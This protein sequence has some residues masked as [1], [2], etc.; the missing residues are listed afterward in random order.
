MFKHQQLARKTSTPEV[1]KCEC[2]QSNRS[3]AHGQDRS[4]YYLIVRKGRSRQRVLTVDYAFWGALQQTVITVS[5]LSN[6]RER[7]SKH[8]QKHSR[9]ST[10]VSVNGVVV[11]SARHF[12]AV[13]RV[14]QKRGHFVWRPTVYNFI[15]N[16]QI[17]TKFSTYQSHFILNITP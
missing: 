14:G 2:E 17:F 12:C 16:E 7:L 4:L 6:W 1:W 8:W 10:K 11:W 9:S 15:N 13:Y 3:V 5:Q